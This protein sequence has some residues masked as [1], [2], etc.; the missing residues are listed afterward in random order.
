MV[1]AN[2]PSPDTYTRV[3]I[4]AE[5]LGVCPF[6][7]FPPSSLSLSLFPTD[8]PPDNIDSNGCTRT[9]VYDHDYPAISRYESLSS[10]NIFHCSCA[11]SPSARFPL[12]RMI[13]NMSKNWKGDV[14]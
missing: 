13:Y 7:S 11:Y 2:G 5:S 6:L 3:F 12:W 10:V 14:D 4:S 1:T 9:C 8:P